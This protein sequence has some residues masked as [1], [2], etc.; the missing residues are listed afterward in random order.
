MP[1]MLMRNAVK[2]AMVRPLLRSI[3]IS[4]LRAR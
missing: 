4:V 1:I 3:R 2:R